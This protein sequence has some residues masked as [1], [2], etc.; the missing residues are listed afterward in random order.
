MKK[1]YLGALALTATASLLAFGITPQANVYAQTLLLPHADV[2]V[3]MNVL[4]SSSNLGAVNPSQTYTFGIVLPSKNTSGLA[5]F[6]QAVSQKGNAQYH[7]FLTKSQLQTQFGPDQNTLAQIQQNLTAAGFKTDISGQMLNVT[8]T[9]GH[10]NSL[11]DTQLTTYSNGKNGRFISPNSA[12]TIPTWLQTAVGIT[13]M[14]RS[15]PRPQVVTSKLSMQYASPSK[16]G[17]TPPGATASATSGPFHV[18]V[19]RI[20]NG[21]RA[22]GEAVRYLVTA[23]LHGKPDTNFLFATGLS[24]PY[25]G[26]GSFIMQYNNPASGQMVTDFTFS[27]QQNVSMALTVTDGTYT[28][29]VQLPTASFVGPATAT[30]SVASLFGGGSGDI[31]AP[32]NPASNSVNTVFNAQKTV[33]TEQSYVSQGKR[34]SIGVFTAGG[35]GDQ[36]ILNSSSFSIPE[37]DEAQFASQFGL[38]PENFKVDYI[39]PDSEV[40]SSYGGIEGEMSLDLQMMETSAPGANIHIYSA[41][42]FN[43]ALNAVIADDDVSVFSISYGEGDL[44][45]NSYYDP[46]YEASWDLLAQQANAE[47][48]TIVASAGDDGGYSG[49]QDI[50][51]G[52]P[53]SLAYSAQTSFPASSSYVTAIGGTEDSVTPNGT[54]SQA[55]LWGGNLGQEIPKTTLLDFLSQQNMMGAGGISS[56]EP[57]PAYQKALNPGLTGRMVPDLS[58]PASVVTPGYFSYFDGSPSLSGGTSAGAPLFSGWVADLSLA[59]NK[60]LGNINPIL[61]AASSIPGVYSKVAFGNNGAYSVNGTDNPVTGLGQPNTDKFLLN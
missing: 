54:L 34:P 8:G 44:D 39:G 49:A 48:I 46:G 15:I 60:G 28:A 23:T 36:G 13:G 32:W 31:V 29:T 42:D 51:Y 30:T 3:P 56:V 14:V 17:P 53:Q 58:L 27:Q 4:N 55:A 19:Q 59:Y 26:A 1:K 45:L 6:V 43:E 21:S 25:V 38:T 52:A 24:G 5:S 7:Q 22:P 20:T 2:T 9:V 12:I 18:T 41:G 61:Y 47:G 57:A 35:I 16:M 37:S 40:D 50:N 10:I 33:A 11:F